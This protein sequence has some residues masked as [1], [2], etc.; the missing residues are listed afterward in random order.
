MGMDAVNEVD[1][2][3]QV[4]T[5]AERIVARTW[6]VLF[7]ATIVFAATLGCSAVSP[8]SMEKKLSQPPSDAFMK[9]VKSDPFPSAAEQGLST[10]R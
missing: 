2:F 3:S 4:E 7:P 8:S 5:M 9:K 6:R 10:K 1:G